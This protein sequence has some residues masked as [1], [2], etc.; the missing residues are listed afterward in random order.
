[1][2]I[3][4]YTPRAREDLKTFKKHEQNEIVDAV[5]A[6]L[7]YEPA[8]ETRNRKRMQANSYAEWELRVGDFRVLY[9]V[10]VDVQVVEIQ[11]VGEKRG[12]LFF[13]RRRREDIE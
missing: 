12:N 7:S 1:M 6:Q 5:D 3:V 9:N 11:R 8:V 2:Y 10:D 13:F 4:E